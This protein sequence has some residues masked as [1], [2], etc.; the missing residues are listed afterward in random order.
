MRR[1]R[2]SERQQKDFRSMR[3]REGGDEM[4]VAKQKD[5]EIIEGV[6][7][8]VFVVGQGRDSRKDLT[9]RVWPEP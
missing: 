1:E 5:F 4:G 9:R 7:E 3:L 8:Q 6:A 2:R